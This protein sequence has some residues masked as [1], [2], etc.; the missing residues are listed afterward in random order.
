VDGTERELKRLIANEDSL[1]DGLV[2]YKREHLTSLSG[3]RTTTLNDVSSNATRLIHSRED[4]HFEA[5]RPRSWR[6]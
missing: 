4:G 1:E 5:R 2:I 6:R 3:R